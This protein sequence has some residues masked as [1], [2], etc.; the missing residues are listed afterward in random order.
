MREVTYSV[1]KLG[2]ATS[3]TDSEF[4]ITYARKLRNRFKNAEGGAEKRQGIT[5]LAGT[6]D[7]Q[8]TGIHEYV[9]SD[10]TTTLF[11]SGGGNIHSVN[12]SAGTTTQAH[13]GLD[14]NA[15]LRSVQMG[16]RL[17]FWNGVDRNFYTDDAGASFNELKALLETGLV[18][19]SASATELT[20]TD[21]TNWIGGT[22]VGTNDLVYNRTKD[23]YGIITAVASAGVTHTRI[24]PNS[25][26]IGVAASAQ[27]AG[28]GYE[29]TDLV[30]L[31]IVPDSSG[32]KDNLATATSGTSTTVVAVSGT[33]FSATEIKVGDIIRNT[34]V[35][36][37][38]VT[39]VT[40]VSANLVVT[41]V[42]GQSSG[43]TLQFFKSAM[44]ISKY[45]HVHFGRLYHIDVREQTKLRIS[46]PNNPT[47]MTQEAGTLDAIT[48]DFGSQQPHGEI[49]K[50][51]GSFQK[52]FMAFGGRNIFGFSGTDPIG[53]SPDFEPEGL[54]PQGL[55]S[56]YAVEGL[57][58]DI[59]FVNTEGLQSI[60]LVDDAS[61]L[62]RNALSDQVRTTL[63]EKINEASEEDIQLVHYP[64][65][66]WL[67]LKVGTQLYCYN[68]SSIIG[69]PNRNI[70]REPGSWQLFDGKFARQSVYFVRK[71]GDLL[72]AGP[73]RK[74]YKAD[75]GVFSD[76]GEIYT[77]ELAWPYLSL[78]EPKKTV[79]HKRGRY[80]KPIVDTGSNITYTIRAEAGYDAE[81]TDTITATVSGG[82][83]PIGVAIVGASRIGGSSVT[84]KKHGLVWKGEVV[85][86]EIETNDSEGPDVISKITLY[87]SMWGRR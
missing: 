69:D 61:N 57:G 87:A 43:D 16:D 32:E 25:T 84:N 35:S 73:E 64:R 51:L 17:I 63:R 27:E 60:A 48:Y 18:S 10:G 74:V 34:A 82:G 2:Y 33:D 13:T 80:I 15:R 86:I 78:D 58:N 46:G 52:F 53:S 59:A 21:V 23:A 37:G 55:V 40:S 85:G 12:E 5:E 39:R 38:A 76:D 7:F 6:T 75:S 68:Y 30:E 28:D 3:F 31:N 22:S 36:A 14:A 11:V 20:D 65:R 1:P 70:T 8:I 79:R 29:V 67:L 19:S 54:F 62:S 83:Q 42:S 81:S 77:T 47:D 24:G 41:A 4:P 45:C 9:A 66:S 72:C 56:T 50:A 44:P 49:L 26:G 71:N